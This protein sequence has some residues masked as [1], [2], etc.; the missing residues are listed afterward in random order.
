MIRRVAVTIGSFALV[1]ALPECIVYPEKLIWFSW[2]PVV[3]EIMCV[4]CL[5]D[6]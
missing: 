1:L 4:T 5:Y 2:V 3:D 6:S